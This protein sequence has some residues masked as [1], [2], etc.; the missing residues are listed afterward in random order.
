MPRLRDIKV[1]KLFFLSTFILLFTVGCSS[2]IPSDYVIKDLQKI[3]QNIYNYTVEIDENISQRLYD[4][5]EVFKKRFLKPWKIEKLSLSVSEAQWGYMYQNLQTYANNYT[6]HPQAFYEELIENSNFQNYNS[7]KQKAITIQN[8]DM[9]VFP[10]KQQIFFDPSSAG[11][12]FPFDYNQNTGIKINTP[13]FISHFSK[14]K[15]WVFVQSGFSFGWV[16]TKH[17]AFVDTKITQRF[18]KDLY[19]ALKDGFNIYKNGFYKENIK[20]ATVFAKTKG[21]NF[22]VVEAHNNLKG[23]IQTIR[24]EKQNIAAFPVKFN[25]ANIKAAIAQLSGQKYGWGELFGQRDCSALT[26]DYFALFGVYLDRNSYAQTKNGKY[27]EIKELSNKEKIEA[28][29]QNATPFSSLIYL[30]GHIMLYL[31]V[32]DCEVLLFHNFWGVTRVQNSEEK[33]FI[34]GK[35]AITSLKPGKELNGYVESKNILSKVEG[36][37]LF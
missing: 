33:R 22:F 16:E 36:I 5:K 2:K 37:V 6:L 30:K 28:I 24:I 12:G 14:D 9:K 7:V 27:L 3:E 18:E 21:G 29:K 8:S 19:I 4:Q 31:G 26:R 1:L 17:I 11:E 10:T 13:V 23:Y 20:L 25:E 35:A 32:Y 15:A 34:V